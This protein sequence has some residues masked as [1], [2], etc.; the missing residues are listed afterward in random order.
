MGMMKR[1][2]LLLVIT[3]VLL[4]GLQ[5]GAQTETGSTRSI[6]DQTR[7]FAPFVSKLRVGIRDPQVRLTW[8]DIPDV[9]TTYRVYRHTQEIQDST[10]PQ[11]EYLETV[12]PGVQTYIDTPPEN[13]T[14][15]YA[16]LAESPQG[17]PYELFIPFR[18]KSITPITIASYA[19]P[20]PESA[21]VPEIV[22]EP[23][24]PEEQPEPPA[25][26]EAPPKPSLAAAPSDQMP[27][28]TLEF[29]HP[30]T[31]QLAIYR[32]TSPITSLEVMSES[33]LL[34][35]TVQAQDERYLDY[36]VPGIPYYYAVVNTQDLQQGTIAF[37]PGETIITQPVTIP[38][39]TRIS[40]LS[41]ASADPV[42]EQ[43]LPILNPRQSFLTGGD[44]TDPAAILMP[45]AEPL[46]ISP[47]TR[48]AMTS[49]LQAYKPNP[50]RPLEP[51]ILPEDLQVQPEQ[52]KGLDRVL[53]TVLDHYFRQRDWQ[54]AESLL[55]N[56]LT[57]PLE[58]DKRTKALFYRAQARY[59]QGNLQV[60]I[61][62]FLLVR[63]DLYLE[64]SAFID[65]ALM[66]LSES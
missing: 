64:S 8:Q 37:V 50:T 63:D 41:L 38:L 28:I 7:V 36:G 23:E 29:S 47:A 39:G 35:D 42:R 53:A 3:M 1:E 9:T 52:S 32:S 34:V 16:V 60:S 14:Y 6:D 31:G 46:A 13:G 10:F 4:V 17:Q 58:Q 20:E 30:E 48:D 19:A 45:L 15:Y 62:D 5:A 65:S 40:G 61:L 18:N 59:F 24:T 51:L 22:Q 55:T 12:E 49:M 27:A 56:L 57:L 26:P 66:T 33:A 21:P 2:P 44:F 54:E 25:E 43:G 11:A